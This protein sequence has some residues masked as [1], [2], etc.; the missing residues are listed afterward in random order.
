MAVSLEVG[1]GDLFSEFLADALVLF[2]ALQAAGT[3]SAAALQTVFYHL[4]HFF[5]FIESYCHKITPF[6]YYSSHVNIGFDCVYL[7][8]V[9]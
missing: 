8:D 1:I 2:A 3:V 9:V 4:D 6:L 7:W 5:V